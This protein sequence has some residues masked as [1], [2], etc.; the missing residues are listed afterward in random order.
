MEFIKEL[1]KGRKPAAKKAP[2]KLPVKLNLEPPAVLNPIEKAKWN[3]V[4]NRLSV[5]GNDGKLDTDILACYCTAW[6]DVWTQD[7]R[8]TTL[9]RKLEELDETDLTVLQNRKAREQV[10]SEYLKALEKKN[11]SMVLV[12]NFGDKLGL[13]PS[14]RK[15]QKLG[16]DKNKNP[17]EDY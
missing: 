2:K 16:E 13:N 14:S 11:R 3:E 8:A 12:F 9:E 1:R 15:R 10:Y 4:L 6:K 17:F 5:L 7:T